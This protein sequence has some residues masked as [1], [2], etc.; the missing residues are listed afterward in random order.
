[1]TSNRSPAMTL[2]NRRTIG[3]CAIEATCECR[4]KAIVDV[5]ALS[6]AIEVPA[7]RRRLKCSAC[8]SRP[9]DVRPNWRE[10]RP[11][12]GR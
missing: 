11:G 5:S 7:L 10:Y 4:H 2:E 9:K 6:G 12:M 3:V 1:M 8:G